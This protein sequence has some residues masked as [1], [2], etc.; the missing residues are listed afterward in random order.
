MRP[1]MTGPPMRLASQVHMALVLLRAG[2]HLRQ[3]FLVPAVRQIA[4]E[5]EERGDADEDKRPGP[6]WYLCGDRT[7]VDATDNGGDEV[8]AADGSTRRNHDHGRE[9]LLD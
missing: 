3:F 9:L 4:K 5:L 1:V 7:H 2:S 6:G 8:I